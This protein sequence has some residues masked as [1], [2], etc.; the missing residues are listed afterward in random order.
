MQSQMRIQIRHHVEEN[1][2]KQGFSK[3]GQAGPREGSVS[4]VKLWFGYHSL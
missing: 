1:S 2:F 4:L 3:P